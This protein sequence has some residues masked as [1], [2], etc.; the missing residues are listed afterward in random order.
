[1]AQARPRR[2]EKV[3]D[4]TPK[5]ALTVASLHDEVWSRLVRGVHDRHAPARRPALATVSRA[6]RPEVRTVVLRGANQKQAELTVHT[7]LRSP[8]VASLRT[9][10]FAELH[11][12]D[13]SAQLQTRLEAHATILAG[14]AVAPVWASLSEGAQ[15]GYGT[16]PTPGEMIAEPL[17]YERQ[18]DLAC[19]RS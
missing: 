18:S 3:G 13:A 7:D 11:V 1:M 17:A 14:E 6:G 4:Q 15:Q 16:L 12:W 8:K 10:P 2:R 9:N 5:W 19:L